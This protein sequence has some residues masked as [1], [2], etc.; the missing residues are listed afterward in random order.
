V[1]KNIEESRN[2]RVIRDRKGSKEKE[3]GA[4]HAIS[5]AK[6]QGEKARQ[7]GR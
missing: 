3:S 2:L 1:D 7:N 5:M 4:T 6:I